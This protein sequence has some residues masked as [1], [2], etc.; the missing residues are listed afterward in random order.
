MEIGRA[1]WGLEPRVVNGDAKET[2]LKITP[3]QEMGVGE[4]DH[5]RLWLVWG[6]GE[7]EERAKVSTRAALKKE[8]TGWV[9]VPSEMGGWLAVGILKESAR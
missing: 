5:F 8:L 9:F 1:R 4:L 6:E 7:K 3:P 2:I